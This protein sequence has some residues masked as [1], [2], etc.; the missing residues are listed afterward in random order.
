MDPNLESDA[1]F[2]WRL[3]ENVVAKPAL[4][5]GCEGRK[6]ICVWTNGFLGLLLV[7]SFTLFPAAKVKGRELE[8]EGRELEVEGRELDV[9]VA[10]AVEV[11]ALKNASVVGLFFEPKE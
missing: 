1:L 9:A 2:S 5:G 3:G 10:V 8:V 6:G 4:C 11:A 7:K